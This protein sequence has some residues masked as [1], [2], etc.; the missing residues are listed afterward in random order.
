M[1]V[2][3]EFSVCL[4]NPPPKCQF[5]SSEYPDLEFNP[6]RRFWSVLGRVPGVAG[7]QG[8]RASDPST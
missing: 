7:F 2:D 6:E 3:F 4:G 1:F 5:S 8:L